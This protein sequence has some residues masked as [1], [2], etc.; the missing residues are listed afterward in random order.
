LHTPRAEKSFRTAAQQ[1][2]A[3]IRGHPPD[4]NGM[5]AAPRLAKFLAIPAK[6]GHFDR[7]GRFCFPGLPVLR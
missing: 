4:W 6:N 3:I 7:K 2:E 1:R 5:L